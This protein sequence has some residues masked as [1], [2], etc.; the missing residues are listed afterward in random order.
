VDCADE[1]TFPQDLHGPPD[2]GIG[3]PVF[4]RQFPLRRQLPD[5][6]ARLHAALYVD[7][8]LFVGVLVRVG[9]H[10]FGWHMINGSDHA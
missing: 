3:H 1:A 4:L 7:R 5:D 10:G 8:H 6:L 2:G 9:I